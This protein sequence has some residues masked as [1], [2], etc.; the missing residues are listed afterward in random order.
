[1]FLLARMLPQGGTCVLTCPKP[2]PLM[3]PKF[4]SCP[5]THLGVMLDRRWA[6]LFHFAAP[7]V[8]ETYL[9]FI[10]RQGFCHTMEQST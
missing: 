4:L 1:M 10:A 2:H 8:G 9:L 6:C 5:T 7:P 3:W